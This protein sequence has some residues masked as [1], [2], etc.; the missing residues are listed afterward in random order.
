ME[1]GSP[2]DLKGYGFAY[3]KNAP[4]GDKLSWA[5]LKLQDDGVLYRLERK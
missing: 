4:Y 2:F 5:L 1:I 3:Q